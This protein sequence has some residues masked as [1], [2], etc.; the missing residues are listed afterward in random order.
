[1]GVT[2]TGA[3]GPVTQSVVSSLVFLVVILTLGLRMINRFERS[4]VGRL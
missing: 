1:M 3:P 2:Q 4:A